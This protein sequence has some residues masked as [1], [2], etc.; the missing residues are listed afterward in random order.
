MAAI[1]KLEV[2]ALI[3]ELLTLVHVLSVTCPMLNKYCTCYL[4]KGILA[5]LSDTSTNGTSIVN[6]VTL[7][8]EDEDLG[9]LFHVDLYKGVFA[10]ALI[11]CSE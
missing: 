11:C 7:H 5:T 8:L 9:D 4:E 2:E 6:Q 1:F 10:L 3:G